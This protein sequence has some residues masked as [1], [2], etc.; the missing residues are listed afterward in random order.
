MSNVCRGWL[1]VLLVS[2]SFQS[3]A[4]R[5]GYDPG[6]DPFEAYHEAIERAD[7]EHKLVLIIAGGDWCSW[8]HAL[9]RF[10]ERDAEVQRRMDETFVVV[11]VYVG[12]DNYNEDFFSQLPAAKGAPHF[13]VV[14]PQKQ[15]LASQSTGALEQSSKGY[16]KAAFLGFVDRWRQYGDRE[17]I[18]A[19]STAA[20]RG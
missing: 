4:S 17:R 6:A 7:R 16:D 14:S 9:D 1:A 18:A 11:K 13:W 10:L 3:A 19:Q 8:C 2:L 12:F 15:V 20:E 5:L